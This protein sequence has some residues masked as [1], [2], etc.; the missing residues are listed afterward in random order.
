MEHSDMARISEEVAAKDR[1]PKNLAK[2]ERREHIM[3]LVEQSLAELINDL[4]EPPA[5]VLAHARRQLR[6]I[7]EIEDGIAEQKAK[8]EEAEVR[9]AKLKPYAELA[10]SRGMTLEQLIEHY[11]GIE[12]R[13]R[14]DPVD[15]I[16]HA[17]RQVGHDP[18]K[19]IREFL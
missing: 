3:A 15:G 6:R 5:A 10:K 12:N 19:T 14:R 18:V 11:L 1:S 9:V 7:H 17:L 8:R 16:C 4:G 2:R 13:I